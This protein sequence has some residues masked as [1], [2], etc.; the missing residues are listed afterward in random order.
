MSYR[1]QK[2]A[3]LAPSS[4]VLGTNVRQL[5]VGLVAVDCSDSKVANEQGKTCQ[6]NCI[7]KLDE[8][9]ANYSHH[10]RQST[11]KGK[12]VLFCGVRRRNT[13]QNRSSNKQSC[14]PNI[15][16]QQSDKSRNNNSPRYDY[17]ET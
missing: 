13:E 15:A 4:P 14:Q 12:S 6:C 1:K 2:G 16:S 11:Y 3:W 5:L 8:C 7:P 9:K 10:R 17:A